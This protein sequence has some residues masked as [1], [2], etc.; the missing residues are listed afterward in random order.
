[1]T[2][3][4]YISKEALAANTTRYAS[5]VNVGGLIANCVY[6]VIEDDLRRVVPE[7]TPD[8][9]LQRVE[10]GVLGLT[11][12]WMQITG[13]S[14]PPEVAIFPQRE[15]FT[16]EEWA[17]LR[18]L[19]RF[20]AGESGAVCQSSL[21]ASALDKLESGV[22]DVYDLCARAFGLT[23]EEVK[24]QLLRAIYAGRKEAP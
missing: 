17:A 20:C 4:R 12:E 7:E 11:T 13:R 23:R 10:R 14:E 1:V 21:V 6:E 19:R 18:G 8:E 9:R 16:P 15:L 3:S 5:T 22:R 2:A 24:R